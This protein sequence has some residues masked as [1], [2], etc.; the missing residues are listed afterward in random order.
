MD[1]VSVESEIGQG[2]TVNMWKEIGTTGQ[3]YE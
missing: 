3:E 2:T 1:G